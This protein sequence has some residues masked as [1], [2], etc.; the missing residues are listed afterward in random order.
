[1]VKAFLANP[2][3]SSPLAIVCVAI[4]L[5]PIRIEIISPTM[6]LLGSSTSTETAPFPSPSL[7]ALLII[8]VS[9]EAPAKEVIASGATLSSVNAFVEPVS[10]PVFPAKSV[11]EIL[12]VT[13]SPDSYQIAERYR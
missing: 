11:T 12:A 6:R 8:K 4:S 5:E 1:M 10:V 7:S 9:P 2:P 3:D 13:E